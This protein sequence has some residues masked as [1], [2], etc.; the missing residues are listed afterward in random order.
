[1]AEPLVQRWASVGRPGRILLVEDN[2]QALDIIEAMLVGAGHET[3]SAMT[4]ADGRAALAAGAFD[5]VILD[6]G[7][8]DGSGLDLCGEICRLGG[9]PVIITSAA[10]TPDERIAGFDA[11]ADDYVPKPLHPVELI[12]RVEAV[13]R[14]TGFEIS[15]ATVTGPHGIE[16]DVRAGTACFRGQ[17]VTLS[18][19]EA[20]LLRLLIER[21]GS[22]QSTDELIRRVWD[23]DDIGDANFLHQHMSRLRR[24]LQAIGYPKGAIVTVYGVGYSMPGDAPTEA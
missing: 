18:R 24:K 3:A 14:R 11:G 17:S 5:L 6:I 19:S 10:G 7:L 23:Y 2:R 4:V 9:P 13:L 21:A 1:M 15:R 8:P 16:L 12:R 22:A 20:G